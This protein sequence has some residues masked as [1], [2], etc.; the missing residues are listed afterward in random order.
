MFTKI[1]AY[2]R[3]AWEEIKKVSW[4]TK[5]ETINYTYL[6]IGVS[7]AV[8]LYLGTLDYIFNYILELLLSR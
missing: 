5:K 6:V 1:N 4:P 7:I 3:Q 8:A 2:I